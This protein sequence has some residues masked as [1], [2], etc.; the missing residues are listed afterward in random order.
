MA[1]IKVTDEIIRRSI[2]NIFDEFHIR[3]DGR[4]SVAILEQTWRRTGLRDAD[5]LNGI[6]ALVNDDCLE[7]IRAEGI[8]TLKLTELG[9]VAMNTD[10]SIKGMDRSLKATRILKKTRTRVPTLG[11]HLK[12]KRANEN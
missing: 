9:S 2:L 10:A 8:L 3:A 5:L 7:P 1:K 12:Q 4:L 6:E 11:E